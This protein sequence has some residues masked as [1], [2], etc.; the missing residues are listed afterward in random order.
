MPN[1]ILPF[2]AYQTRRFSPLTFGETLNVL[3]SAILSE[4]ML[5][6]HE[7]DTQK[8]VTGSS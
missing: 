7:I 5:L 8:I 1:D 2:I 6:L 3:R 4:E